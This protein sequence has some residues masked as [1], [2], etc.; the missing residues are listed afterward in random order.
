MR[1]T[2]PLWGVLLAVAAV[3][4]WGLLPVVSKGVLVKIDAH[5]LN[6][7]RFSVATGLLALFF[8]IK[9]RWPLNQPLKATEAGWLLLAVLALLLNHILFMQALDWIP[10][11][12]SQVIIQLGPI[13]LLVLSVLVLKE[14]FKPRQWYGTALFVFG[15]GLYFNAEMTEILGAQSAYAKGVLLMLSA[16]L[17]WILYGLGQKLL[18]GRVSAPGLLLLTYA[19]GALVLGPGAQLHLAGQLEAIELGFLLATCTL[20]LL[21]YVCFGEAIIHWGAAKS[22]AL[23]AFIPLV[24]L[25]FERVFLPLIPMLEI[26]QL[27]SLGWLGAVAV[28]TG[29]L[30]VV[31]ANVK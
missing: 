15:L 16:S 4:C 21:A 13:G 12:A 7:Y 1:K 18:S 26:Q 19:L 25:G 17:I 23:L 14:P 29:S 9:Q 2:R 5:T 27:N 6:F 11:G 24:A 22:S 10:A 28:I 31:V 8:L 30:L 20:S 3:A